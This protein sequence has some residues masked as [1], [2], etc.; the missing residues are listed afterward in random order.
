MDWVVSIYDFLLKTKT[1]K[2]TTIKCKNKEKLQKINLK[3][4]KNSFIIIV[5]II[6]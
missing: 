1:H 4:L 5:M 6:G 2:K 3:L